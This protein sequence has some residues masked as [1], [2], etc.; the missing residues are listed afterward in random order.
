MLLDDDLRDRLLGLLDEL[1]NPVSPRG[2]LARFFQAY[3]YE[4][5]IDTQ[6]SM[7]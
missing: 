2:E 5:L 7:S 4:G 3:V 1:K 6:V